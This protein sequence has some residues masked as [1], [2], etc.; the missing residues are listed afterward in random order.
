MV[1]REEHQI[2]M[3]EVPGSILT[4]VTFYCWIILFSRSTCD[5]NIANFRYF[6]KNLIDKEDIRVFPLMAG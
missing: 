3:V 2:Q 1:Q 4:S 6:V 5:A